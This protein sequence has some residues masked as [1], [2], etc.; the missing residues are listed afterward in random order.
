[1][2]HDDL[3]G[4]NGQSGIGYGADQVDPHASVKTTESL[5]AVDQSNGLEEASV[6][7]MNGTGLRHHLETCAQH[8]VWVCSDR[9]KHF[10]AATAQQNH[11]GREFVRV[12]LLRWGEM[13]KPTAEALEVFVQRELDDH[14]AHSEQAREEAFVESRGAFTPVY[15]PEG[16][17]YVIIAQ[18]V[19]FSRGLELCEIEN[20]RTMVRV[21][22][23][24]R[25]L[26]QV[27]L[28]TP[29]VMALHICAKKL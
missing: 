12:L 17:Q 21:F 10:R 13:G 22:T 18:I 4:E 23:T 8:L 16:I 15:F 7:R 9:C 24:H 2:A 20:K 5:L 3:V 6:V 1:M 19:R 27:V 26:V 14:M 11:M 25:G 29:A 28:A